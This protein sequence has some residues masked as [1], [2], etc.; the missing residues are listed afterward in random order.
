[1]YAAYGF[2]AVGAREAGPPIRLRGAEYFGEQAPRK[3]A[4]GVSAAYYYGVRE[5]I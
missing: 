5:L 1:M 3:L 4:F 2:Y